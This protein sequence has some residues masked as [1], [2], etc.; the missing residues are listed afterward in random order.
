ML[1]PREFTQF[2]ITIILLALAPGPDN[3]FIMTQSAVN[4]VKVGIFTTLGLCTGLVIHSGLAAFGLSQF[5]IQFDWATLIL[6]ILGTLY[7]FYLARQCWVAE[8]RPEEQANPEYRPNWTWYKRGVYLNLVNPKVVFFFLAFFPQFTRPSR[9]DVL[10][11]VLV[12]GLVFVLCTFVVFSSFACFAG[13]LTGVLHRS[14]NTQAYLNKT[15]ALVFVLLGFH[16]F[17]SDLS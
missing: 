17:F 4:G 15:A 5:I 12:L 11:Q 7:L 1:E 9:G 3:I 16:L 14:T 2:I 13:Q 6:K 10:E 8:K